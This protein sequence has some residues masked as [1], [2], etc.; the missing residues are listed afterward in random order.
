MNYQKLREGAIKTA[1]DLT[2]AMLI[3][4]RSRIELLNFKL[5]DYIVQMLEK[6]KDDNEDTATK[7]KRIS[8]DIKG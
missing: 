6:I 8:K 1:V 2:E 3:K 5:N 4:D 7:I